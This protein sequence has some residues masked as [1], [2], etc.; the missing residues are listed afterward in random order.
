MMLFPEHSLDDDVLYLKAEVYK[1]Q[2]DYAKAN[3]L[4][5]KI[6]EKYKEGIRADNSLFEMAEIYETRLNDKEKAKTLYEKLF[7]DFSDS[8]L[9]VEARKRFRILRGDKVGKEQ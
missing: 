2:R 4:F 8:T 3:A 7:T 1:K 9:A 5:E 6:I